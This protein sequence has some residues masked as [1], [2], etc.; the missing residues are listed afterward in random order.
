[1]L[2]S[3]RIALAPN[4]V[5]ATY[6]RR[7][8]GTARFAYNWALAE[9]KR[10]Y[11]AGGRPK[12]PALSRKLTAIKRA[13]FP[14]MLEVTSYAASYAVANLGEAYWRFFKKGNGFPQFKKKG[15][16]DS[17]QI[18]PNEVSICKGKVV[19]PKLGGV[20]MCQAPRWDGKLKSATISLRGGRW[21]L[22]VTIE[23]S[24]S[25]PQ[26]ENQAAVGVDL[27]VSALATLSTGEKVAGPKPHRAL[28][29]RLRRLNKSLHRKVKGSRNRDKAKKKLSRLHARKYSPG[30]PAQTDSSAHPGIWGDWN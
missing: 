17:F 3:Q 7:A 16:C 18:H 27:G 11:E 8:C 23:T 1:M 4:N 20:R 24:H 13:E 2:I 15:V 12:W 26:S 5:Q 10:E 6:F 21:F 29:L 9:W 25:I 19:I 28:T 14:W 22:S 30:R